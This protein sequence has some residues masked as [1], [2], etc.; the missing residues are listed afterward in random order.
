VLQPQPSSL[1]MGPPAPVVSVSWGAAPDEESPG[2]AV[3][4]VVSSPGIVHCVVSSTQVL[5]SQVSVPPA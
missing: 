5:W 2:N 4:A 1:L 3:P